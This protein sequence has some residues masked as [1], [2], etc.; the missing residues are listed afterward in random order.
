MMDLPGMKDESAPSHDVISKGKKRIEGEQN[1]RN[2]FL[3]N[4]KI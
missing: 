4:R 1:G 3:F 2:S